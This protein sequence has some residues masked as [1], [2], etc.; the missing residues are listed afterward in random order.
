MRKVVSVFEYSTP[1]NKIQS[2]SKLQPGGNLPPSQIA[3]KRAVAGLG[4]AAVGVVSPVQPYFDPQARLTA[5][6]RYQFLPPNQNNINV[7]SIDLTSRVMH[8]GR[9][10]PPS[11]FVFVEPGR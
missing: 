5:A 7:R 9:G 6:K 4:R 10:P 1:S 2:P 8:R 3:Y 11:F